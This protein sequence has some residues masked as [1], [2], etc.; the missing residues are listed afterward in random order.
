MGQA[1]LLTSML[2]VIRADERDGRAFP[3]SSD[4]SA[5]SRVPPELGRALPGRA[6]DG[7]DFGSVERG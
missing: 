6:R 2:T 5:A 7:A 3:V 4:P 1:Y